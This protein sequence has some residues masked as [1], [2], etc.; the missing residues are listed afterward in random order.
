MSRGILFLK[1][2][3]L[4]PTCVYSDM[5]GEFVTPGK[6]PVALVDRTGVRPLV[7]RSLAGP[8]GILPGPDWHQVDGDVGRLGVL[9]QDL[10]ALAG[11]LVELGQGGGTPSCRTGALLL[12]LLAAVNE[13]LLLGHHPAHHGLAEGGR[14]VARG[15]GHAGQGRVRVAHQGGR[16]G[17]VGAG[18]VV[19]LVAGHGAQ[20]PLLLQPGGEQVVSR[21][22]GG[23]GD[24]RGGD[25]RARPHHPHPGVE[26][27]HLGAAEAPEGRAQAGVHEVHGGARHV[28]G[29]EAEQ[30]V[31]CSTGVIERCG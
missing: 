1:R 11:A 15:L 31:L 3:V 30:G 12:L 21:V 14:D 16:V 7:Y 25:G 24:D 29:T 20:G 2:E 27:A 18:G 10:V 8:V 13:G 19:Q 4:S 22:L 23:R 5:S 9:G 26:A 28:V 17:G 6:P